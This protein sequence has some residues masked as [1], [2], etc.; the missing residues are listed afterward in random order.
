[1]WQTSHLQNES[2]KAAV[3]YTCW[4]HNNCGL[5][6][7]LRYVPMCLLENG[8]F[9]KWLECMAKLQ[10][11]QADTSLSQPDRHELDSAREL[12]P[13][14]WKGSSWD[15]WKEILCQLRIMWCYRSTPVREHHTN[16]LKLRVIYELDMPLYE[17]C[18]LLMFIAEKDASQESLCCCYLCTFS[19]FYIVTIRH[20]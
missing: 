5:P 14:V 8:I 1:M 12:W 9:Q 2:S 11:P 6:L 13:I 4:I 20:S 16:Q 15:P 3:W 18:M 10:T 7:I 17:K 19:R